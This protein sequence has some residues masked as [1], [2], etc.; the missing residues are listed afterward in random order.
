MLPSP[1]VVFDELAVVEMMAPDARQDQ[2]KWHGIAVAVLGLLGLTA[3]LCTI[4]VLVVTGAEA[5]EENTQAQWPKTEARIEKCSVDI[6]TQEPEAYWIDCSISYKV[7]GEEVASHIHSRST[8]APRRVIAQNPARQLDKLQE[9][10]DQHPAG[11]SILVHYDPANQTKAVL[12]TTD[13]PLGGPR[14]M[15]NLKLLGL[16]A[17]SC[18][19]L[20]TIARVARTR[21][22]AG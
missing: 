11:T 4:F 13:I 17:V 6:Y 20:L 22:V 10:V 18:A 9:W 12:V 19:A 3:G 5:W 14:T 21:T 16:F 2:A 8:P 1:G 15:D 7:R